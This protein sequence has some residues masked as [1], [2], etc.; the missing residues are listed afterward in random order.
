[1]DVNEE[2]DNCLDGVTLLGT[3]R[4]GYTLESLCQDI[5]ESQKYYSSNEKKQGTLPVFV[6]D[7]EGCFTVTSL[8]SGLEYEINYASTNC[9]KMSDDKKALYEYNE[10]IGAIVSATYYNDNNNVYLTDNHEIINS[11]LNKHKVEFNDNVLGDDKNSISDND[12]SNTIINK[13]KRENKLNSDCN[14]DDKQK[15]FSDDDAKSSNSKDDKT[16]NKEISQG[17]KD[18]NKDTKLHPLSNICGRDLS[19]LD[20]CHCFGGQHRV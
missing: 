7:N 10:K 6:L 2:E 17:G 15:D 11:L 1:M 9:Y 3:L 13:S 12:K 8:F 20:C 16:L 4:E 14:I 19:C 5:I 18:K